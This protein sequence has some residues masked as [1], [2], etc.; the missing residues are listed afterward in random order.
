MPAYTGCCLC[1]RHAQRE[2]LHI[3]YSSETT[4]STK[5]RI[6]KELSQQKKLK[7]A[8][9]PATATATAAAG[10]KSTELSEQ[11]SDGKRRKRSAAVKA[12]I[13]MATEATATG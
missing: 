6:R 3:F 7:K 4:K 1:F 9:T 12:E 5:A 11:T 10:V 8:K 13:A 2:L